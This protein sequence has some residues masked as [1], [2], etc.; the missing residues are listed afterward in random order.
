V[1]GFAHADQTIEEQLRIRAQIER[2]ARRRVD[3][4]TT[5]GLGRSSPDAAKAAIE[6]IVELTQETP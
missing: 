5:C 4:S 3:V 1:A 2:L 6:R